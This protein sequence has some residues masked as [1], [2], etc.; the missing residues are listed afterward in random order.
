MSKGAFRQVNIA[1][2][3]FMAIA[4]LWIFIFVFPGQ[5]PEGLPGDASSGQYPKAVMAVWVVSACIWL[6]QS[7][8]GH[9][10]TTGDGERRGV[11]LRSLML[12]GVLGSGFVLFAS[13]GFVCA[14]FFMV[15]TLS[16][17]S[18]ERGWKPWVMALCVPFAVYFFLDIF[19]DVT[20]PTVL[21]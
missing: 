5:I 3:S 8:A 19:L 4:G 17:L 6:F 13:F 18:G 9:L 12:M 2:A 1:T 16:Y 15:L 11:T 14:A 10:D 7:L 20:L 21:S